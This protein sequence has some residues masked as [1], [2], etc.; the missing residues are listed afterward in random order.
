MI[1]SIARVSL[2]LLLSV[3]YAQKCFSVLGSKQCQGT[4]DAP[5]PA[6]EKVSDVASLDAFIAAN[7]IPTATD[8]K[9]SFANSYQCPAV[10]GTTIRFAVSNICEF[11]FTFNLVTPCRPT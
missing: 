10:T 11:V 2:Y 3:A 5:V 8:A 9:T 6:F 4:V 7:Y 1:T